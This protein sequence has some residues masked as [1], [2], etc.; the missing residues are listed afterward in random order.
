[1][2]TKKIVLVLGAG[3]SKPYGYPVGEKLITYI[4]KS[5]DDNNSKEFRELKKLGFED[6]LIDSFKSELK[7]SQRASIDAFLEY[8]PDF[9]RIGK[10]IIALSLLPCEQENQLMWEVKMTIGISTYG[11][12]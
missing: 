5:L 8:R 7:N 9:E 4:C 3:A 10:F 1:M 6:K 2:I 12:K 11:I